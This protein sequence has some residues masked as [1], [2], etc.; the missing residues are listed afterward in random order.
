[1]KLDEIICEGIR[2]IS[3]TDIEI[4][5]QLGYKIKL[6]AVIARDFEANKLSVRSA[7]CID[8]EER[9]DCWGR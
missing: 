7:P 9:S 8:R 6:L 2:E 5:G 3:G 4:A 1:M